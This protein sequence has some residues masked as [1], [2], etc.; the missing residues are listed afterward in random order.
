MKAHSTGPVVGVVQLFKSRG[1]RVLSRMVL[2]Y[3]DRFA[4][5]DRTLRPGLVQSGNETLSPG[6]R[7]DKATSPAIDVPEAA[8]VPTVE[9]EDSVMLWVAQGRAFHVP[10]HVDCKPGTELAI[11]ERLEEAHVK[12]PRG[13]SGRFGLR[14]R[15][16]YRQI[17]DPDGGRRREDQDEVRQKARG[18]DRRD[19]GRGDPD[20]TPVPERP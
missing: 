19:D 13:R 14:Q 15:H 20:L 1:C 18:N 10:G 16:V 7:Y 11:A 4:G 6:H 9:D 12:P 5:D 17:G 3:D 2:Y 8:E